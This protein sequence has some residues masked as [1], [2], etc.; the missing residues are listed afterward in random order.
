[1]R[2][3]LKFRRFFIA[4]RTIIRVFVYTSTSLAR[5][6]L[7]IKCHVHTITKRHLHHTI[8]MI[9]VNLR[10]EIWYKSLEFAKDTPMQRRVVV[11]RSSRVIG[12]A[13]SGKAEPTYSSYGRT[14]LTFP[15][16]IRVLSAGAIHK[17][18]TVGKTSRRW[19]N[20]VNE[21]RKN[22]RSRTPLFGPIYQPR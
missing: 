15:A 16:L 18:T 2:K 21:G 1:M 19:W 7:L 12:R 20:C 9:D 17:V 5:H 11:L 3:K 8:V 6:A 22:I 4:V 14:D 10:K 13:G